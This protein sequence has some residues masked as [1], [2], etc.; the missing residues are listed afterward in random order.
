MASIRF[1]VGVRDIT[2]SFP[3]MLHGYGGRDRLSGI[4]PDDTVTEP[5]SARAL[6][7]E[8][9]DGSGGR[10]RVVVLTLDMIGVQDAEATRLR[11]QVARAAGILPEEVLLAASHTHFAPAV[12]PQL[13]A[14]P[15]LGVVDP[16][17]RYVAMVERACVEAAAAGFATLEAGTLES[18]RVPVPSVLFNRRT[19]VRASGVA[20]TVE[21]NFLYPEHRELFELSPVDPELIALRVTTG[22]GPRAVLMN[23]G[24]HPVT[25]GADSERGYYRIS[26]DYPFHARRIVEDAWGDRKSVV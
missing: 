6:C 13:F 1:G 23:F 15:D 12:S 25:G 5:V 16:D 9:T 8:G 24:C 2:P 19:I 26:S 4:H 17:P 18:Y 14:S 11:G 20:R 10:A 21:T 22:S 7:L 3:V